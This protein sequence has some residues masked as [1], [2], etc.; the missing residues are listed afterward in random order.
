MV[1]KKGMYG[2]PQAGKI[3]NDKL[4]LHLE[5]FG[6]DSAPINPGLWRHQTFPLQLSLLVDDSEIKY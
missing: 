5:K 2:L 4:K 6:Y 3:E 1:I